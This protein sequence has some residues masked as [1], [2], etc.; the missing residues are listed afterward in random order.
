[1]A[2]GSA[3]GADEPETGAARPARRPSRESHKFDTEYEL[4][5][6]ETGMDPSMVKQLLRKG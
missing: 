3:G 4:L 5:G 2:W 6:K 1:M